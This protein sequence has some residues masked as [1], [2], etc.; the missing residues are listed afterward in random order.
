M[1]SQPAPWHPRTEAPTTYDDWARSDQYHND[2]LLP[3]DAALEFALENSI[4]GGLRPISV[5]RAQGRLLNL[6]V[7]SLRARKIVE[8][9][10]L[11]GYAAIWMGKALP[12]DGELTTIE[13][14]EET[15]KIAR[16]SI[17][18]AGLSGKIKVIHGAGVDVLP[19]LGPDESFDLAFLDADK[20]SN[21]EYFKEAKRLVRKGGVIIVDNVVRNA[22][23]ADPADTSSG[24]EGVRRLLA[25]LKTDTSVEAVTTGTVGD[26]GYD[27]FLYAYKL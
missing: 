5:S 18:N 12:A 14:S 26:K 6:L 13:I 15:V 20:E 8:V 7:K 10:T 3:H 2:H 4:K 1:T 9:G 11:G 16:E 24:S 27:G 17:E 22:E 19:T 21:L 25:H 23:V